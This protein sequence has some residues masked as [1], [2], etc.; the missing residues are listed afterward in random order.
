MQAT[1]WEYLQTSVFSQIWYFHSLL[2]LSAKIHSRRSQTFLRVL[3]FLLKGAVWQSLPPQSTSIQLQ[4]HTASEKQSTSFFH[5]NQSSSK[6]QHQH[7]FSKHLSKVQL[8]LRKIL[9]Q[10]HPH[11]SWWQTP[12][13]FSLSCLLLSSRK[14]MLRMQGMREE[15]MPLMLHPFKLSIRQGYRRRRI[16][17]RQTTFS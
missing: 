13:H 9:Q 3:R 16:S 14:R 8:L 10:H 17:H 7:T 12:R 5:P 6:C 2:A 11:P 4:S 15:G 1:L